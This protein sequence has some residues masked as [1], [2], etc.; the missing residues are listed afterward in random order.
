M[1][2]I[3]KSMNQRSRADFRP[4]PAGPESAGYHAFGRIMGFDCARGGHPGQSLP[5][6][7]GV[8]P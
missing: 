1:P 8:R 5:V 4:R 6:R 3:A 7:H 2:G